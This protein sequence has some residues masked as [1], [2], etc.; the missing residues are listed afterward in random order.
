[1][2]K[3]QFS[4]YFI[5]LCIEI[6]ITLSQTFPHK[7]PLVSRSFPSEFNAI[8][9]SM[10]LKG[11]L[12][13]FLIELWCLITDW[14]LSS[15]TTSEIGHCLWTRHAAHLIMDAPAQS[16]GCFCHLFLAGLF[17]PPIKLSLLSLQKYKGILPLV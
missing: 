4:L 12:Q 17:Q 1:M 11:V 15:I 9:T 5:P 3:T 16:R 2:G 6:L 10:K 8:L 7:I 13:A 14:Q